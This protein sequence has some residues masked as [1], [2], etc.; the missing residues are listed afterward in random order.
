[1]S[2]FEHA[3]VPDDLVGAA[4]RAAERTGKDVAD[5]S[6]V[7]IAREAGVSRSTLL[8]R[9][10]GTRGVLDEAVRAAG[11]DP[12][13]RPPVRERA[14]EAGAR[15]MGEL[16]LA[17]TTAEAVAVAADCSVHSVYAAFGSRD[18]LLAEIFE[19]HSP[20]PGLEAY[21]AD[22]GEDLSA[23]VHGVH[24]LVARTLVREPRV[25]PALIADVFAR[26]TGPTRNLMATRFLPRALSVMGG[27]LSREV[28]GGRVR[29]LPLPLL[30]QQLLSP[31]VVHFSLRPA[32][33]GV[34]DVDFP[35]LE[36][37]C[38]VFSDAFLRA[39]ATEPP[40]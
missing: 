23:T 29:D 35:D 26:P 32:L 11:V 40:H 28:A 31:V 2:D 33:A 19:R 15:M 9:L 10:G 34:P 39:V 14:A 24:L 4:I 1:M 36:G 25:M 13:G 8:R 30:V 22:A 20:L 16:G 17:A 12:G 27:W 21:L 38:A 5:V 18:G 6:L 3:R 7:E 37:T